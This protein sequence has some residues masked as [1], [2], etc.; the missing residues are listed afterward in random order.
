MRHALLKPCL[1]IVTDIH[2]S[3]VQ[4]VQQPV[5]LTRWK[6]Q[7]GKE[8]LLQGKSKCHT[9]CCHTKQNCLI[10]PCRCRPWLG[11]PSWLSPHLE[12]NM[13][14]VVGK[15]LKTS[16]WAGVEC[17]CRLPRP[18]HTGSSASTLMARLRKSGSGHIDLCSSTCTKSTPFGLR[19]M[20]V[21]TSF[22]SRF[23]EVMKVGVA[24]GKCH[25]ST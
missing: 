19:R 21:E 22:S 2:Q 15:F 11:A 24:F 20:K 8:E 9:Q 3:V 7:A 13:R 6:V 18:G 12:A 5:Q 10:V 4:L 25:S 14:S 23:C 1:D 16:A 17:Q